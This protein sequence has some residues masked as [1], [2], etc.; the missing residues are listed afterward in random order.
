MKFWRAFNIFM[1]LLRAKEW[2]II[3]DND[4]AHIKDCFIMPSKLTYTVQTDIDNH[5]GGEILIDKAKDILNQ[6]S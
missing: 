6:Q 2:Y 1:F 5:I 3:A 4:H